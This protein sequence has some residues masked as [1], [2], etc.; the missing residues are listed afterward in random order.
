MMT[1]NPVTAPSATGLTS[2]A[3]TI[4]TGTTSPSWTSP[5][6]RNCLPWFPTVCMPRLKIPQ[7][8]VLT[9]KAFATFDP[10]LPMV[11]LASAKVGAEWR[12]AAKKETTMQRADILTRPSR[13]PDQVLHYGE[14]DDQVAGL[15]LPGPGDR[16]G[17]PGAPGRPGHPL[18]IFLHGGFWRSAI[19]A[20][21]TGPLAA[22]L[23]SAGFVVCTPE[24]RRTGQPGGGWPGTFD[25]VAAAVD[26]LP[27]IAARAAG[28]LA[29]TGQ[30]VLAGHSAGGHLALWAAGRR[31]LPATD[32]WHAARSPAVGVVS[33]AGV[34]DLAACFRLGLDGDA[35]GDL[36]GGGPESFPGRYRSADPMGLLPTGIAA[37]L[38]HGTADERVPADQSRDYTAR[39]VAAGDDASCDLLPGCGHFELIDPL[40]AAWPAVLAAFRSAAA[41]PAR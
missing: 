4:L 33:L 36:M 7:G 1:T 22:A 26:T 38:V 8:G 18:V 2:R 5:P 30:V 6:R 34:C 37:R 19:D 12:G 16:P 29:G 25:D 27:G 40:S 11:R 21:H 17:D 32:R 28:G 35:A 10:S 15:R 41:G 20:A 39:A 23:A 31:R 14:R 3:V 13:P 9:P 24:F